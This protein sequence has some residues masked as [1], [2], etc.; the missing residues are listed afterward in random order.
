M[1]LD[2]CSEGKSDRF[3]SV[4]RRVSGRRDRYGDGREDGVTY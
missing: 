4:S 1:R 3:K 2:Y